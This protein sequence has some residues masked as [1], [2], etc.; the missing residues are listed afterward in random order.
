VKIIQSSNWLVRAIYKVRKA[1]Q[2]RIDLPPELER[3]FTEFEDI[4]SID[5]IHV[6]A[7][8]GISLSMLLFPLDYHR[9]VTGELAEN[10]NYR[11]LFYF[12][13]F[14]LVFIIPA[15][16]IARRKDWVKA[17]RLRRGF[18]IWGMVVLTFIFLFGMAIVV[19][20]DRDGLIMYMGFVFISDVT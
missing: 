1:L 11:Y 14:G 19:F 18:H 6:A 8:I 7:W 5:R 2:I 10:E 4:Q 12:H 16:S 17:S 3:Q 20:L 13:V 15:L 9:Y